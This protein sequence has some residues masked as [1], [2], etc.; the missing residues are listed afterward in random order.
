MIQRYRTQHHGWDP[1]PTALDFANKTSMP[2]NFHFHPIGIAARDGNLT[3]KLPKGKHE[4]YT[5]MRADREAQEGSIVTLPVLSLESMINSLDHTS[6]AVLKMDVEGAEFDVIRKWKEDRYIVPAEQLL[7][8]FHERYFHQ[9]E[10]WEHMVP[11]AIKSLEQLGFDLVSHT[12]IVSFFKPVV[13]CS[14]LSTAAML[15]IVIMRFI[16][17]NSRVPVYVSC[18]GFGCANRSIRLQSGS[19]LRCTD[20]AILRNVV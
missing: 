4:S 5:V 19:L 18:S 12:K 3:L 2:S 6:L 9:V 13:C 1:T 11:V 8:E 16:T 20:E 15:A 17:N 10:S 7:I 14:Q